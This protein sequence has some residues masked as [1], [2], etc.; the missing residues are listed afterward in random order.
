[1]H[2]VKLRVAVL[3]P[4]AILAMA[5]S[6]CTSSASRSD[7]SSTPPAN[8]GTGSSVSSPPVAGEDPAIPTESGPADNSKTP[9]VIGA[10]NMDNG[11][12]SF[13]GITA[14]YDVAAKYINA[15]LGGIGGH[16]VTIDHCNAGLDV[17]SNQSCAQKFANDSKVKVLVGGIIVGSPPIY[18]I[19]TQANLPISQILPLN[20]KDLTTTI[21]FSYYPGNVGT[22]LGLPY[23]ALAKLKA[24]KMVLA[25][26]DNEGGRAGA[27]LVQ[28]L[29]ALKT[30][31]ATVT[32]AYLK[33]GEPDVTA[34]LL[35][36]GAKGADAILLSAPE[37]QCI[38]V[39]KAMAQLGLK[40]PVVAVGTCNDPTVAAAV[41]NKVKGWYIGNNGPSTHFA[42]GVSA[43][44]DRAKA[45]FA[46]FG[47]EKNFQSTDAAVAFGQVLSLWA[48][49][50]KIGADNLTRASWVAG[51]RAY[52]GPVW[53]GPD[54]VKCPGSPYLAVC[55]ALSQF[56]QIG[57][58]G[59]E[60]AANDGKSIDPYAPIN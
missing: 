3:A 22:G 40:Q 32:I 56:S 41:G 21:G 12:P 11:V 16:P 59:L 30:A 51:M 60:T 45:I 44:V 9:I 25:V 36:A 52:T 39:A 24:K 53:M 46:E 26:A 33:D 50:N 27:Q 43:Q 7:G 10:I 20:E 38:Q 6:A 54:S 17:A 58:D 31:G 49:G 4:L 14:G 2:N 34:P 1:M 47:S 35:A 8:S 5:A 18:P 37:A 48:I 15:K 23:F 19:L 13:P 57:D 29:P 42:P 28:S 55:T